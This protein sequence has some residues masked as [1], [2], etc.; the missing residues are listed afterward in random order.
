[1]LPFVPHRRRAQQ[2]QPLLFEL[3]PCS[4]RRRTSAPAPARCGYFTVFAVDADMQEHLT[5]R[6]W[7]DDVHQA[8]TLAHAR[9][10]ERGRDAAAM[11]IGLAVPADEA[12][13]PTAMPLS[14]SLLLL[15]YW[16]FMWFGF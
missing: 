6:V 5:L 10:V 4:P 15:L 16:R 3:D 9:L 7:A 1:M 13:T 12:I 11:Q 8:R 2:H 14:A